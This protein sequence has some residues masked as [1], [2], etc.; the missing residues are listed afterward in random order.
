MLVSQLKTTTAISNL[1]IQNNQCNSVAQYMYSLFPTGK[2]WKYVV[3]AHSNSSGWDSTSIPGP[4]C[5]GTGISCDI[6]RQD[7]GRGVRLDEGDPQTWVRINRV[8]SHHC[9]G[10][11]EI[12][13]IL[14]GNGHKSM[15]LGRPNY[16]ILKKNVWLWIKSDTVHSLGLRTMRYQL[17]PSEPLSFSAIHWYTPV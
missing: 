16:T 10:Y 9:R 3:R 11:C 6:D 4:D 5:S 1:S 2:Q 15:I 13:E 7:N 17:V 8:C 14:L 12:E